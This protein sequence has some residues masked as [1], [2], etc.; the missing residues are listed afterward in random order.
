MARGT[1]KHQFF[2]NFLAFSESLPPFVFPAKMTGAFEKSGLP[3]AHLTTFKTEAQ[4][5]VYK[6]GTNI[7]NEK[8]VPV[9]GCEAG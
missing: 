5:T 8:S 2:G 4:I 3:L 7:Q 6:N 1:L 9:K